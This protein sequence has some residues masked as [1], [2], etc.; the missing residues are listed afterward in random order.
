MAATYSV[1]R[2]EDGMHAACSCHCANTVTV[3]YSVGKETPQQQTFSGKD[4]AVKFRVVE[5]S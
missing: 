1:A 4:D 5:L 3:Y 2:F